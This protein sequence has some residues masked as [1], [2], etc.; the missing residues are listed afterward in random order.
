MG[1]P[2]YDEL[3]FVPGECQ[4][5]GYE[6][7]MVADAV[8]WTTSVE[9]ESASNQ[10]RTVHAPKISGV[11]ITRKMD[12]G[13][14]V[15]TR[16]A[17]QARVTPNPWEL[18]FL[19][20]I[21]NSPVQL[22]NAVSSALPAFSSV[23]FMTMKLHRPLITKY[24]FTIGEAAVGEEVIEVSPAAIE[25]MYFPTDD[26]ASLIGVVTIKYDVQAGSFA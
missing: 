12:G 18:F 21:G 7:M 16:W 14:A 25:W 10:R 1:S 17:L 19:K 15:L 20:S 5:A 11:R 9:G 22:L 6:F 3:P 26:S 8:D 23:L 2:I 4:I 24:E 13:T